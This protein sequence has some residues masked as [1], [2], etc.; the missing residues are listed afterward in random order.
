[1][2]DKDAHED[3][4][5][6]SIAATT[7]RK[8]MSANDVFVLSSLMLGKLKSFTWLWPSWDVNG[9]RHKLLRDNE[10]IEGRLVT[11]FEVIVALC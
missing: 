11:P 6:P 2:R 8:A 7:V 1:L 5:P 3:T 10:H 4:A 9:P